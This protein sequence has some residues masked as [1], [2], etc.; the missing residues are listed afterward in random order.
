MPASPGGSIGLSNVARQYAFAIACVEGGLE[1]ARLRFLGKDC[2]PWAACAV[3]RARAPL[4]RQIRCLLQKSTALPEWWALG[5]FAHISGIVSDKD[6][7]ASFNSYH[8]QTGV[9]G[10]S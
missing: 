5:R 7:K 4:R 2:G 3:L 8:G 10:L 9:T 6:L 1:G